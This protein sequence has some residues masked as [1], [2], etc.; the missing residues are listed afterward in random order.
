[1]NAAQELIGRHDE[2]SVLVRFLGSLGAGPRA[3]LVEGEAGIGKTALWQAGLAHA[4]ARGQRT[5]VCRPAGSEVRLSFAAL[6]DLLAGPLQEVLADLPLPQRRALQ[7]ALLLADPEGEPPDQRAIGLGLL[8]V[9]RALSSAGPVLV[10]ID[11][12]QWLD[13]P[14]AAVLA[15]ALR[16]LGPEPVG[17]LATVRLTGEPPAVAFEPWLPA[18]RLRLGP[19][20]LAAVHELLRTRL[21]LSPSRPTLVRLHQAAGGNPLFA[22][23]LGRAL[24]EQ[25]REPA[26]DEPLPVPAS[27]RALVRERLARLPAP[28]RQSLLAVAALSRPTVALAVAVGGQEERTLADLERAVDAEVIT[29]EDEQIR[30]THPL[31]ASTLYSEAPLGQRRQLHGRLAELV[32]DGEERAHHLALAADGPDLRVAAALEEAATHA[33]LRGAPDAAAA[34][35]E[36]ACALTPEGWPGELRRRAMEA[37]SY[38]LL[39]GNTS[40]ARVLL[41]EA[42]SSV[43]PGPE[44]ARLLQ[45]LGQVHYHEDSWATAEEVL[46]QALAEVGD[47]PLVRC[48]I[49][50][51]LSFARHVRG[52]VP[53]AAARAR[54]ALELAEQAADPRL[55]S[56]S[57]VLV[58]LHEF[59]LGHGIRG[60][61]MERAVELEASAGAVRPV[62]PGP[63][64]SRGMV[65]ASMLKWAD[66]FEAARSGFEELHRRML[67]RGD[68]A[69]LAFLLSNLSELECWA[70]NW[71]LAARYAAEGERLATLTGQGAMVSAN[72]Y[73]KALVEAHRG[74]VDSARA[75]GEQA[76]A[77]AK[78]SGNAAVTLMSLSAL[79]FLE[80]SLGDP[81]AA[82][83]RLAPIGEGLS[84]VGL[85]EPGVLRFVPDETQAL[86]ELGEL[87]QAR[88]LVEALEER[89]RALD[90]A[91]ALATGARSRALLLAAQGDL[92]G[93][94]AA[95]DQALAAHQRLPQPFEHGRTLLALGTVQRRQGEKRAARETLEQALGIFDH[96][97]APLWAERTRAE[98]RRIGGRTTSSGQLS[99]TE[100]RIVALVCAGQ[101]N[102]QVARALSLSAKTVAWNLSKVYRKLGVRSRT[103]LA[104]RAAAGWHL[105]NRR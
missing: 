94:H 65:W 105:G 57:L 78:A 59:F 90:R 33:H 20:N 12:A 91:W 5:L 27:L 37:A 85:G 3:L 92:A 8:N 58:S 19:L 51:G 61:L 45:R 56:E 48:E 21:G 52:D 71:D 38:H 87:E 43:A 72:L 63:L 6:G 104:A 41:E 39:A 62:R 9:L 17:V 96:L 83:A 29:Y 53:A 30:F 34:L 28:A 97:G 102:D 80:L 84:A 77:D 88:G 76:L 23:E 101:T 24:L 14:S 66:Q 13:A 36:Q 64:W 99:E 46:S 54:A 16:R 49:E 15:F 67:E 10:A 4:Q 81:A 68:E 75:A 35:S 70:G 95:L 32:T 25:G 42:A 44:R 50:Q 93:A 1:M 55:L 69:S 103:E 73:A 79:G 98:L 7:V 31:L 47:Q 74:L 2:L 18:E 22:L 11:D 89:G 40:R 60:D 100:A 82:H 86:I 26:L